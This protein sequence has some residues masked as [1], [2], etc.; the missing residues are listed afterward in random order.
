MV[1][2]A[3]LK[4][5]IQGIL[6]GDFGRMKDL[7]VKLSHTHIQVR[8]F[9][10]ELLFLLRDDLYSETDMTIW[11]QKVQIFDVLTEM[12][13][14]IKYT[15]DTFLLLEMTLLK[16][17]AGGVNPSEQKVAPP[18][19]APERKPISEAPPEVQKPETFTETVSPEKKDFSFS[20]FVARIRERKPALALDL[21][22]TGFRVENTTLILISTSE[23]RHGRLMTP[24]HRAIIQDTLREFVGGTWKYQTLLEIEGNTLKDAVDEVF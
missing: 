14:K 11:K 19:Q 2:E 10:E 24:E 1:D 13:G 5:V 6:S 17:T 18:P 3:I 8:I 15:P 20:Q 16:L 21:K 7:L 23:L 4:N 9:V 12:Y 22:E